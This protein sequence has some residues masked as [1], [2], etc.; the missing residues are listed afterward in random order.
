[1]NARWLLIAG[2]VSGL[3][4]GDSKGGIADGVE[5]GACYPNGTCNAGLSCLSELCVATTGKDGGGIRSAGSGGSGGGSEGTYDVGGHVQ[6][7]PFINGTAVTV[8]ELDGALV[9]TGRVFNTQIVDDAGT[10]ILLGVSLASSFV[11]VSADGFY[12]DEV[13]GEL[14]EERLE[15]H[16]LA[17]VT[18]TPIVNVN[19]IGQLERP[20]VEYLIGTGSSFADAK[21]QAQ[22]EV[23]AMFEISKPGIA[24]SEALDISDGDDDGA[25][26]L[27]ISAITQGTRTTGALSELL[28]AMGTDLREDGVLDSETSGSKL[29]DSAVLLDRAA[30]RANIEARYESLGMVVT[31]GDFESH[32]Q[33]FI[34][35]TSFTFTS[36]IGYP[37]A[38]NNGPSLLE[39]GVTAFVM[40]TYSLVVELPEAT[41][42]RV[43]MRSTGPGPWG[44]AQ[45]EHGDWTV[46]NYDQDLGEQ[47]FTATGP[48]TPDMYIGLVPQGSADVEIYENGS[49]T[50]TITKSITWAP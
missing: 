43:L 46:S 1:M 48:G 25:I 13:A 16:M 34:D 21:T 3:G 10:F 28:S 39:P 37:A 5:K 18:A 33:H 29:L 31:V 50:P 4:C 9:A 7:G 19:L 30:V 17:D 14:S 8:N 12:F 42:I 22:Q 47:E 27:A 20:R 15:L 26:L 41:S 38:G 23:L 2:L 11:R 32:I 35:N 49:S 40:G 45:G 24:A 44:T 6:K 36:Q